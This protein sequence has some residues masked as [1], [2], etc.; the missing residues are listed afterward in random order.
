[1]RSRRKYSVQ[2][3]HHNVHDS[4]PLR[5]S[6][7]QTT[8]AGEAHAGAALDSGHV[9]SECATG[10]PASDNVPRTNGVLAVGGAL[11]VG[12]CC[13]I[14]LVLRVLNSGLVIFFFC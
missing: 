12:F 14:V 3:T 7:P 13:L 2:S 1:M 4:L 6:Q 8:V 9:H 5:W 10:T 11:S